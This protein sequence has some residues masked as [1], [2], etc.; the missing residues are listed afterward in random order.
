MKFNNLILTML[1]GR[2]GSRLR[3]KCSGGTVLVLALKFSGHF[4]QATFPN[5]VIGKLGVIEE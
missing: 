3:I 5:L 1:I 4:G 2:E